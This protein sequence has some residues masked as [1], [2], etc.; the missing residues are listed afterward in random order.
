MNGWATQD[1]PWSNTGAALDTEND[2]PAW[3]RPTPFP[4]NQAYPPVDRPYGTVQPAPAQ[5]IPAQPSS[6]PPVPA[7]AP[8]GFVDSKPP[9]YD[10]KPPTYESKLS[11]YDVKPP[12]YEPPRPAEI[13]PSGEE[14]AA[15]RWAD[16]RPR[17]S[18][19]LAHLT[20]PGAEQTRPPAP[21]NESGLTSAPR[22]EPGLS[23]APL[24]PPLTP[25]L[26]RDL[27]ETTGAIGR[28][29]G[30]TSRA[31]RPTSLRS[32]EPISP[33]DLP[34]PNS[35]PP[36]PYEGDLEETPPAP[37]QRAAVP[38]VRP[39]AP[40]AQAAPP[41]APAARRAEWGTPEPPPAPPVHPASPMPPASPAD[42]AKPA[43][44]TYDPSSFPRRISYD[45]APPAEPSGYTPPAA[46]AA[47]GNRPPA[48][49]GTSSP[50]DPGLLKSVPADPGSLR[51]VAA[52]PGPGD[53]GPRVLPQRVPAQPDV[54][55]VPEPPLT[56][57]TAETPALA[58]IA[59]HLR[60]G[61][62]RPRE[63]QEGFDV[64]AILAAVRGVD[65]VRDASLRS[66]PTGAHSLRLD[67]AE[68]ADPAEV[69]RRVARLLQERMGLDAAMKGEAPANA[70][71]SPPS[72]P[73]NAPPAAPAPVAETPAPARA[74][75]LAPPPAR[76]VSPSPARPVSPPSAR[77]V[78]PP[79]ARPVSLPPVRPVSPAAAAAAPTERPIERPI[80]RPAEHARPEP[81]PVRAPEPERVEQAEVVPADEPRPPRPLYPGE[82]PG[83]RIV[84]ENVHVNT[85]GSD[86]T[87]E[88]RLAVGGRSTSG[89]ASGPAV[90]G[91]LL[92]L[93]AMATV[94]AVDE[95]LA[96]SDHPDGPARCFVEHAASVP[97]GNS[98][99][100]VVV[101]LLSCNGW[102]EQLAG[103]A[104]VTGD[105]RHAM[106]RATLAAVNRRL[107]ALLS[108]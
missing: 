63:R 108:R 23:P 82:H 20:P 32:V 100:A 36:Y 40:A 57:P 15:A 74:Q 91:Y 65:G 106:V 66:T 13:P 29:A 2:V 17:Y 48:G 105:D 69:S 34:A 18:D 93:C 21:R 104:V 27:G 19:L 64:Q 25:Q 76:P 94:G 37:P 73:R 88:V 16:A 71:V 43:R 77:P 14:P 28:E 38:L 30:L 97:F 56:E 70:P 33:Y 99:V 78:S 80:E 39:A 67:L 95:L 86:A 45:P 41:T 7:P 68:G 5:P 103:S 102:V 22:A 10:A 81:E 60:R 54:P 90:D 85:F 46:Y 42:E 8:P 47:F 31:G 55:R 3:R 62:V 83:P 49:G 6:A 92:R 26:P 35:A 72:P 4:R 51:R 50:A 107:E 59:T 9:A 101:L 84:L 11:M 53:A 44:P 52:D 96:S 87:V 75:T 61:D 24:P 89:S 79:S 1:S 58:R 98:Q 12:S